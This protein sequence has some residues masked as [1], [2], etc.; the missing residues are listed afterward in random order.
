MGLTTSPFGAVQEEPPVPNEVGQQDRH[1]HDL[2]ESSLV[3]KP[4][5][6]A[7]TGL[8][9]CGMGEGSPGILQWVGSASV[10]GFRAVPK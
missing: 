7:L 2:R 5:D 1:N 3:S 10:H 8:P 9:G 4:G 6:M